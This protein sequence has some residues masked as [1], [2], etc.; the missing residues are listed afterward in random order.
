MYGASVRVVTGGSEPGGQWGAQ[1]VGRVH[2]AAERAS[3]SLLAR[4]YFGP[5]IFL[6]LRKED[7]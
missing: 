2:V 7:V 1:P 3:Q 4:T 6:L 5:S